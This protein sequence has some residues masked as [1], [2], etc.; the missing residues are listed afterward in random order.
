VG[1]IEKI[2]NMIIIKSPK[3]K[4]INNDAFELSIEA[5][6]KINEQMVKIHEEA[7]IKQTKSWISSKNVYL[8]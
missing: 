8:D 4:L 2:N 5:I 7:R 3:Q 1:L 6:E